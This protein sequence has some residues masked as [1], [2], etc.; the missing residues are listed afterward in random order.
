[1]CSGYNR[2]SFTSL[3]RTLFY[4]LR[5]L[6]CHLCNCLIMSFP[7]LLDTG[8][9]FAS[10]FLS[11]CPSKYLSQ[12]VYSERYKLKDVHIVNKNVVLFCQLYNSQTDTHFVMSFSLAL[13]FLR[14]SAC[15]SKYLS[16]LL[17]TLYK[18][19]VKCWKTVTLTK[20]S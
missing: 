8:C 14:S 1:M 18:V 16:G 7:A 17:R 6:F 3:I 15:L 9:I 20:N 2:R 10:V 4:L 13:V 19:L 12:L 5:W 11:A